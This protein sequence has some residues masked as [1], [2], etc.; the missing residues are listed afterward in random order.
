MKSKNLSFVVVIP[1]RSGSMGIINKNTT[2]INGKKLIE[3][4][5]DVAKKSLDIKNVFLTTNDKKVI[6]L[7]TKYHHI[8]ILL[9]NKNLCRSNSLMADV[10]YDALKIITNKVPDVANFI[11]LQPTSPQRTMKDIKNA[12]RLFKKNNNR[13][14]ISVSEPINHPNEM[15]S[16]TKKKPLQLIKRN[17]HMNRQEYESFYFINGSIFIGSIKKFL[18][19]KKFLDDKSIFFKMDKKNSIDINDNFDKALIKNFL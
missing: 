9:R 8:N 16:L 12:I 5:F 2:I 4:T 13:N 15:I 6:K 11:L 7:A 17:K 1:A 18:R 3:Y 19:T 10:I 14:V